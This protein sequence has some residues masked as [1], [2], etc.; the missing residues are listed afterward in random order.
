MPDCEEKIVFITVPDA[1]NVQLIVGQPVISSI[2]VP[3]EDEGGTAWGDGW[4]GATFDGKQWGTW[5]NYG[6]FCVPL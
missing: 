1:G 4:Y 2:Q 3:C 6:V 5:F